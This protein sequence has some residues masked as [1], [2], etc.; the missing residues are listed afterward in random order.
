MSSCRIHS[1]AYL[2]IEPPRAVQNPTAAARTVQT[3]QL[4]PPLCDGAKR[5]ACRANLNPGSLFVT[6]TFS[7]SKKLYLDYNNNSFTTHAFVVFIN[8]YLPKGHQDELL[9]DDDSCLEGSVEK[10]VLP[11]V[12]M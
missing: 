7:L 12:S 2:R 6:I 5:R 1:Y 11:S 8:S 9:E 3:K 10:V 4:A